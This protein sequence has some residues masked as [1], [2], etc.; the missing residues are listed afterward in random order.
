MKILEADDDAV[1]RHVLEL[2]LSDF[3]Y[4]VTGCADG[5]DAWRELQK[6]DAP[7]IAILDWLMPGLNGDEICRRVR[8]RQHGPPAYL[9]IL[10]IKDARKDIV[11]GLRSGADDY[12]PKPFDY[13]E[14]RARVQVGERIVRWQQ[15]LTT[16]VAELQDALSQVNQLRRIIP[17]CTFCK[18]VRDDQN[19]WEQVEN[20][21]AR[22]LPTQFSQ[23]ICP[24]C[25]EVR[26]QLEQEAIQSPFI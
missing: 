10:T 23:G 12:V 11:A 6:P 9:I 4:T 26:L 1:C 21:L 13:E 19:F 8:A 22:H 17:I 15:T 7:P 18:K 14:L 25:H 3:G 20:Y 5:D 24:D 2:V 16:R